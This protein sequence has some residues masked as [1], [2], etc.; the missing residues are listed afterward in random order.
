[1]N[2]Y[3]FKDKKGINE[4][5]ILTREVEMEFTIPQLESQVITLQQQKQMFDKQ[6]A[7]LQARIDDAKKA[8]K[9]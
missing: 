8:L 9:I 7:D 6:I 3:T 5:I 1:M 4:P 2:T